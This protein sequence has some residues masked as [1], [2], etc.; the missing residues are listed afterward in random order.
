MRHYTKDLW[1]TFAFIRK[2]TFETTLYYLLEYLLYYI[3]YDRMKSLQETM[4]DRDVDMI[5]GHHSS[6]TMGFM[7]HKISEEELLT[8]REI[9]RRELES[10][11]NLVE[12]TS[13]DQ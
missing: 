12:I 9:C 7:A 11:M 5:L 8:D 4:Q 13:R 3:L 2:I 10:R 1:Y 6:I